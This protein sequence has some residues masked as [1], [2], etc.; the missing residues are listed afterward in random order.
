MVET[1]LVVTEV[2]DGLVQSLVLPSG[3]VRA[4]GCELLFNMWVN[5]GYGVS[6]CVVDFDSAWGDVLVWYF[7]YVW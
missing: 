4:C 3:R 5:F 2:C 6:Y 7:G 1:K